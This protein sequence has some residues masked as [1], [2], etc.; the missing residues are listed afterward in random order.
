MS[1]DSVGT[2]SELDRERKRFRAMIEFRK[3]FGPSIVPCCLPESGKNNKKGLLRSAS[4]EDVSRYDLQE[5]EDRLTPE[6]LGEEFVDKKVE[7]FARSVYAELEDYEIRQVM[8]NS[9]YHLLG[10]KVQVLA[11]STGGACKPDTRLVYFGTARRGCDGS[12]VRIAWKI[13]K[14]VGDNRTADDKRVVKAYREL[15]M[16]LFAARDDE[17]G[18]IARVLPVWYLNRREKYVALQMEFFPSGTLNNLDEKES[19]DQ[20]RTKLLLDVSKALSH[21]HSIGIIHGDVR[22][23]N[24]CYGRHP[25]TRDTSARLIDLGD[26]K[27]IGQ[28]MTVVKLK[29]L[30]QDEIGSKLSMRA[31][32]ITPR[33]EDVEQICLCSH[34]SPAAR[35]RKEARAS[36]AKEAALADEAR[37]KEDLIDALFTESGSAGGSVQKAFEAHKEAE[38]KLSLLE[39]FGS[40]LE[41]IERT[42]YS[43]FSSDDCKPC[44]N[45]TF[46]IFRW[47][48]VTAAVAQDAWSLGL[49]IHDVMCRGSHR[50]IKLFREASLTDDL[51]VEFADHNEEV[52][53]RGMSVEP[54]KASFFKLHHF[55]ETKRILIRS[56][57]RIGPS[58]RMS[59]DRVAALLYEEFLQFGLW[60]G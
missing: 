16:N 52:M 34:R 54:G 21:L 8:A 36:A 1:Y 14:G 23:A 47:S 26:V 46:R 4:D 6:T 11:E 29:H 30:E 40:P 19:S 49:T 25:V 27:F 10:D 58:Q 22:P 17:E 5:M 32:E 42:P 45:C 48:K 13:A 9:R 50:G 33:P 15:V 59:L 55:S 31:P 60:Y 51:F 2:M 20:L 39:H 12:L 41:D 56:L 18:F 7:Q 57:L 44:L 53:G 24:I 35:S 43:S 3:K 28:R 37:T 38:A